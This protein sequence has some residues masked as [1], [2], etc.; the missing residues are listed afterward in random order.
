MKH[1][2]AL[3]HWFVEQIGPDGGI[4]LVKIDTTEQKADIL[5]KGLEKA[6]FLTVRKLLIG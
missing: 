4:K 1:I 6:T 5:M 2:A 3:Y